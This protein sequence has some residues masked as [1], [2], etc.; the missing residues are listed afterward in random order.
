MK[1]FFVLLYF[2]EVTFNYIDCKKGGDEPAKLFSRLS[3]KSI[4]TSMLQSGLAGLPC[5]RDTSQRI[6]LSQSIRQS[7]Q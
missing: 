3:F 1:I 6:R 7:L 5:G 4:R 2:L